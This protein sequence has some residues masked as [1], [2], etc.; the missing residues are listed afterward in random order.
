MK[1][2]RGYLTAEK[3]SAEK[4][5]VLGGYLPLKEGKKP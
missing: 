3:K 2:K 4:G 5:L 1:G